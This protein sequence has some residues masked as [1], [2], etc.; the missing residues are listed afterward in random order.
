MAPT[1]PR[2][3]RL[4]TMAVAF[5]AS[6]LACL[7]PLAQTQ[8]LPA[9]KVIERVVCLKDTSQSYALYLPPDYTPDRQWPVIYAFDPGGRGVRPVERF[10]DAA[11]K[12]GHVIIGSNNSRNGPGVPLSA[13]LSA[14]FDDTQARFSIDANR[15]YT[16][17][18][19]GG[20]RVASIVAQSLEGRIAGVI[21]CGAGFSQGRG[22]AKPLSFPVFGVAGSEDFNWAELRQLNRTLDSIGSVNRFVTFD[23]DHAWAPPDF[24]TMA[25]EWMEL[26]AMKSGAR[27]RDD[28]LM[29]EWFDK[30]VEQARADEAAKR[31]YE[32]F[33]KYDAIAKDFHG[34]RD[35]SE[36][37]KRA[38]E[39]KASREVKD[40]LKQER[41][42]EQTQQRLTQDFFGLR[43]RLKTAENRSTAM[44]E[45]K[46]AISDLRKKAAGKD[47]SIDRLATRRALGLFYVSMMEESSGH[48]S[49]KNY[50]EAAVALT[51][52]AEIRPDNPQVFFALARACALG[53]EKRQALEALK[54]AVELGFT[55]ADEIAGN[56]DFASIRNEAAYKQLTEDAKRKAQSGK[57]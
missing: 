56:P 41:T 55:N 24:F 48:R 2:K 37:A 28:K 16:T 50:P 45:I 39:L 36:F 54:K 18:F 23:G 33:L 53:G 4:L 12:Y 15:V 27:R 21:L 26:Q 57:R 29:A 49:A 10:K 11:G 42:A 43:E 1:K 8:E 38:D 7:I 32:A 46:N 13:I 20:A 35:T 17:G 5:L 9:G 51:L 22:P 40:S 31:V 3:I 14:L 6:P 25:V 30:A 19:S 44:M 47:A 34:L 52:A